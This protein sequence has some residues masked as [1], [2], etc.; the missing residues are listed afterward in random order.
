MSEDEHKPLT[1]TTV[2]ELGIELSGFREVVKLQFKETNSN[3][4]ELVDAI[5]LSNDNKA[6]KKDLDAL[7]V[8]VEAKADKTAVASNILR[9]EAL[10]SSNGLKTT[11]MWIGLVASAIINILFIYNLFHVTGV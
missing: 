6:D 8:I 1:A 11:L 4:S 2:R 3:I 10:S 5:K 7:T 9:I